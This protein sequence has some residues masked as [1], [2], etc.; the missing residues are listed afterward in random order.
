MLAG[1]MKTT[2][3]DPRLLDLTHEQA[4]MSL[5]FLVE[6]ENQQHAKIEGML[7]LVW[8]RDMIEDMTGGE[9]TIEEVKPTR[10]ERLRY[11]LTLILKPELLSELRS[12]FNIGGEEIDDDLSVDPGMPHVPKGAISMSTLSKEEFFRRVGHK[13]RDIDD[14]YVGWGGGP[15]V[16]GK[17]NRSGGR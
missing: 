13:Q 10:L 12:R 9:Q 15:N 11:P 5:A 7:G 8:T 17:S 14:P 1:K 2:I 6:E 4:E 3:N 16:V